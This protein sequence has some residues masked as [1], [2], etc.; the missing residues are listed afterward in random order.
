MFRSLIA[1]IQLRR[2]DIIAE[3]NHKL[4]PDKTVQKI[5]IS[6][7]S[8]MTG[9]YESEGLVITHAWPSVYD[10][11]ATARM[12][13]TPLSRSGLMITF[14]I[15][16]E[17]RPSIIV[18]NYTPT[19][20]NICAYL[21]VLF[22]KRFDC[23]GLVEA[24]G[25]YQI[26]DLTAYSR[27]CDPEL[28]YNSHEERSCFPVPLEISQIS[29][30]ERVFF[31]DSTIDETLRSKLDAICK[32]YMQALQNAEYDPEVAYL[33]L[34]TAGEILS[35]F[36]RYPKEEMLDK[37]TI[38]DLNIVKNEIEDGEKIAKRISKRL[39]SVKK[40]F[41]KSLCSLLDDSFYMTAEAEKNFGHFSSAD[42]EKHIGA[43]YDLRSIYLHT[44][45]SFGKWIEPS[46]GHK[47]LQLGKPIVDDKKFAKILRKAPKFAGLERLIR[48]C[49]LKFMSSH[50]LLVFDPK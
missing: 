18:P 15:P 41:V 5:L 2:S 47:D 50:K 40:S 23:H 19:G 45:I 22:G 34:I 21:S 39:T 32:F 37:R 12:L 14:E 46:R 7:T 30:I 17:E 43:A 38:E 29:S 49:T 4:K 35:S 6:T 24:N 13:E 9:E 33:N 48:Y 44:G 10:S 11:S 16:S 25:S 8:R 20:E 36:F 42:I 26:P 27:I 1:L 28:P 3:S 31:A